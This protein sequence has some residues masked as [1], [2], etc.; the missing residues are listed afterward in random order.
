MNNYLKIDTRLFRV[1]GATAC[2]D[3]KVYKNNTPS[4]NGGRR[5]E[6][7]AV[8]AKKSHGYHNRYFSFDKYRVYTPICGL[9]RPAQTLMDDDYANGRNA[10]KRTFTANN[11]RRERKRLRNWKSAAKERPVMNCSQP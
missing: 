2:L 4:N 6:S 8:S 5:L 3:I 7:R 10:D 11:S 1:I 9:Q